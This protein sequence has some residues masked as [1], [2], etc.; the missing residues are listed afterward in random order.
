MAH[1]FSPFVKSNVTPAMQLII[2]DTDI[3]AGSNVDETNNAG[4]TA[5][6]MVCRAPE[7]SSYIGLLKHSANPNVRDATGMTPLMHAVCTHDLQVVQQI[8]PVSDVNIQSNHGWTAL[9]YAVRYSKYNLEIVRLLA[10]VTNLELRD[11][12]G[13]TALFLAVLNYDDECSPNCVELLVKVGADTKATSRSGYTLDAVREWR[14][15]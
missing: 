8:L 12:C 15:K 1:E 3:V 9:M 4:W 13:Y 6:H 11:S 14:E 2:S 10:G 7:Y 5:L